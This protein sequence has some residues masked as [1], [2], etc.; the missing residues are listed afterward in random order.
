M[1]SRMILSV[2]CV[3]AALAV[4]SPLLLGAGRDNAP[5]PVGER[6]VIKVCNWDR[7]VPASALDG[8]RM[9]HG[10]WH[11]FQEQ[12]WRVESYLVAP[13]IEATQQG[14]YAVLVR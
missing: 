3:C 7:I 6:M 1:R 14:L 13:N 2:V 5:P 10:K 11:D 4:V 12:G 9:P 8:F